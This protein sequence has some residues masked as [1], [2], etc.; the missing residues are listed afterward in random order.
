MLVASTEINCPAQTMVKATIP[1]GRHLSQQQPQALRWLRHSSSL[2]RTRAIVSLYLK[3]VNTVVYYLKPNSEKVNRL[4]C[5]DALYHKG[6][7]T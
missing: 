5:E 6:R 1:D 2:L 4:T 3:K 7:R